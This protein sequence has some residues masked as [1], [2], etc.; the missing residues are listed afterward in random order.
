LLNASAIW[1]DIETS[2]RANTSQINITVSSNPVISISNLYIVGN[3]THGNVTTIANFTISSIGNDALY[4]I[5]INLT[6]LAN[7]TMV[8][9]PSSIANLSAGLSQT[10]IINATIPFAYDAGSSNGSINISTSNAGA[11]N[12]SLQ[13]DVLADRDWELDP[14]FCSKT[15]SPDA[16]VVCE[17]TLNNT[18]NAPINFSISPTTA[19]FSTTNA[20]NFT[21]AK[22]VNFTFNI[23][24]N[25]SGQPKITYN[26]T[27]LVNA[28]IPGSMPAGRTIQVSLVPFNS[29]TVA[30]LIAPLIIQNSQ[31]VTINVNV[32]DANLIGIKNVTAN[33]TLPNGTSL[34][35]N[36]SQIGI[37][38]NASGNVSQWRAVYPNV[39]GSTALIGN[40]SVFIT[41]FDNIDVNGT[42]NG[43]FYAY[44]LPQINLQT[45]STSYSKGSTASIY[46]RARDQGG[47]PLKNANVTL[48]V[49]DNS[50][51]LVFNG[52]YI[53]SVA[54]II[55][56]LPTFSIPDDAPAG[57]WTL[58]SQ[59]AYFDSNASIQVTDLSNSTFQVINATTTNV[60]FS[61]LLTNFQSADLYFGGDAVQFAISVYDVNGAPLDPDSMNISVLY[62]NESLYLQIN[63]SNINRS[64][65]GTY[66]Y[67]FTAPAGA[68]SGVYRAELNASKGAFFTRNVALFRISS[69]LFAD[70]ET[71]F[72]WYPASVMT[73]RMVVYTGDGM[74]IDPTS[75]NLTVI[76]PAGNTYFT[77]ALSSMTKQST[78]YYI[79]NFAMGANTS[80]GN[81]YAQLFASKD[82]ATTVKLKPFR[83]SQGG[84][85]D[86]RLELLESTVY[87]GDYLDFNAVMEN[88]GEVTQDVTLEYWVTDST[89]T[90]YYGSEAILTPAFQ[91]T[92]VVRSAYI[93]TSQPAGTYILHGRVTYDLIKPPIDVSYTFEVAKRPSS[94]ATP[95]TG[96]AGAA[97][98]SI[99][100]RP[101]VV[102]TQT[103]TPPPFQDYSGM[104][105]ISYP[106]E[107][108]IQAG[109]T[110]Y[111]KIQ[112]KNTGL[113]PLHNVT[114]TLAGIPLSWLEV[115]PSRV[116]ALAP[117]DTA[118]FV[119]KISVPET[120]RTSIK[121]VRALALSSERKE[122]V[123]FDVAIFESKL[124]LIEHQVLKL[125]E[126]L[127]TLAKDTQEAE[128]V[129][130][131]V[132]AVW[133]TIDQAQKYVSQAESELR[134]EQLDDA[135]SNA[136]I[137]DTLLSKG[138]AQLIAAPFNPAT[139]TQLPNWI[140]LAIGI[141][142][143]GM[144]IIVFFFVRRRK[145][146]A[147]AAPKESASV[148]EK[149]SSVMEKKD[150][151]SLQKEKGK[152]MRALRLLEE[153]LNDG[154]ISSEAY[155]ELKRR[156]DRKIAEIEGKLTRLGIA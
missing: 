20:T 121:S 126:R 49:R 155:S 19:N 34:R 48:W 60:S 78:G 12:I 95:T 97:A 33:I 76:D 99:P 79:Y 118:A 13:V 92:S 8:L 41:A 143:T 140:T 146:D 29:L 5:S 138:K 94:T 26:T 15:E 120:E 37:I 107:V 132:A 10:I 150:A 59:M 40:Y 31:N 35:I 86:I 141:V 153:E 54:G 52:S 9:S 21:I 56:P 74:P 101:G 73:F 108:A 142:G 139:Y 62:P 105:I 77:T 125:K 14:A 7:F 67:K 18:G 156:Y 2:I 112:I 47:S 53:T 113:T 30:M 116:N 87:P 24:Y 69:S 82:L 137:A 32:T 55:E 81:Y 39:T 3:A 119:L 16:G 98:T 71:S 80:T 134:N 149:V 90:W 68:V 111:P 122:E 57:Y 88:K 83:V 131:N 124:A 17:I 43:S 135:L 66:F 46:F 91:N 110:K 25:V 114:V 93:F 61:G 42:A 151:G 85:Y 6:G 129:G 115:L 130:K 28:T 75:M 136:Q 70:V 23:T 51:V 133:E 58:Y 64:G 106:E 84:P 128:K 1:D 22:Q 104:Q 102:T 154:T 123:R 50:S 152:I 44:P 63:F 65:Q 72:V 27:F 103:P 36:L 89:Q 147:P 100:G 109:E 117:G 145:K 4:N 45:L 96:G 127:A 38:L 148:L 144:G 11:A